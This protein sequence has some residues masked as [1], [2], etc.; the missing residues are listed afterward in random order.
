MFLG[1]L[2]VVAASAAAVFEG[3]ASDA[4]QRS[5]N[6]ALALTLAVMAVLVA[7]VGA[8]GYARSRRT[9]RIGSRGHGLHSSE[10]GAEK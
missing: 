10:P 4:E 1:G 5:G 3:Y 2:L 7:T 6:P 9:E 8:I